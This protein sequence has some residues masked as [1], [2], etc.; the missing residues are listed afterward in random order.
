MTGTLQTADE[1]TAVA[2][3]WD[4]HV[5]EVDNHS[6]EA[7]DRLVRRAAAGPGERLLELA[8]GPGSLGPRWSSI[9]G[10]EGTVLLSDI[11]PGM[12]EVAARRNAGA[13]NV[14]VRVLDASRIDLP[15]R[16]VDVVVSR[17]GLQFTP[18]PSV[19]LGEIHRVLSP[20]GRIGVQTWGAIEHNP[21]MTCVGM[22]AMVHGLVSGGPPVGPGTIF[23]LGDPA[24]LGDLATA[25]GFHDVE[26]E[27]IDV[28]FR[29]DTI[30]EHV[31]RVGS[32][33]GAMAASFATATPEQRAA[34]HATAAELAGQHVTA[35]GVT[36]PGRILMVSGR[37]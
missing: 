1:W 30:A 8:A 14:S 11:A 35:V 23:A 17:M 37:V 10:P 21:W 16:A 15:D 26:V 28:T 20:G 34:V 31:D 24:H 13:S 6:A 2:D 22:A 9:V 33:A 25:A 29:A 12:V 27:E 7:T 4:T 36:L 18:D 32:L 5:D 19:A 3:A